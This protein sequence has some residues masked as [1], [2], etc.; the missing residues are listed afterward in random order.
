MLMQYWKS[1]ADY[2]FSYILRMSDLIKW[3]NI[4]DAFPS[5]P[6]LLEDFFGR[7]GSLNTI[8][9]GSVPA[10]NIKEED[11]IFV[12]TLAAPGLKKEDF[13]I[14]TK[15]QPTE[16]ELSTMLFSYKII[17]NSSLKKLRLKSKWKK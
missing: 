11:D 17:K 6:S 10:V 9:G 3:D 2:K 13:K 1:V 16:S 15:K 5:F 4:D 8:R 12:V 14:A 7:N